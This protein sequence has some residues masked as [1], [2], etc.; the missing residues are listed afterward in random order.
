MHPDSHITDTHFYN[1]STY[2]YPSWA[3][4]KK[5]RRTERKKGRKKERICFFHYSKV[6]NCCVIAWPNS[7]R[8]ISITF[9]FRISNTRKCLQPS[10][11]IEWPP[12]SLPYCEFHYIETCMW[13]ICPDTISNR[14]MKK[15]SVLIAS[16]LAAVRS[17]GSEKPFLCIQMAEHKGRLPHYA[18]PHG[19]V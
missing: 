2:S 4:R 3:A 6:D 10:V 7:A 17:L 8:N 9:L 5:E 11:T 15:L 12:L 18:S 1:R 16:C 13:S 19:A 14:A